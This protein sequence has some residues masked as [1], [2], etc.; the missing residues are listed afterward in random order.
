MKPPIIKLPALFLSTFTILIFSC[1]DLA[2]KTAKS[3]DG[4]VQPTFTNASVDEKLLKMTKIFFDSLNCQNCVVKVFVDKVYEDKS[5]ITF[6]GSS[7]SSS[8]DLTGQAT[9]L[10]YSSGRPVYVF[11]GIE[12]LIKPDTK[13]VRKKISTDKIPDTYLR[14]SFTLEGDSFHLNPI[15]NLPFG[16]P[17]KT[18]PQPEIDVNKFK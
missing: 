16:L 6:K 9:L 7:D 8:S 18:G 11:S 5:I 15:N 14:L 17:L 2:K 10:Y 4:T 3:D 13:A 12:G 1:N